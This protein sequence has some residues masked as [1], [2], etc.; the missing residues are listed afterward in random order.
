M[1]KLLLIITMLV[2]G[3]GNVLGAVDTQVIKV[4]TAA[5]PEHVYFM[6]AQNND[7]YFATSNTYASNTP[8]SA[9]MNALCT[10]SA[11]MISPFR[12]IQ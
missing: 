11:G 4:S 12:V 2:L 3:I 1:K 7:S 9:A 8:S 6:H 5:N 10:T